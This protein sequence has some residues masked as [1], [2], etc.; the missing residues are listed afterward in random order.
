M[1]VLLLFS[2]CDDCLVCFDLV[3]V[4]YFWSA[5]LVRVC[6]LRGWCWELCCLLCL[7][8]CLCVWFVVCFALLHK[9]GFVFY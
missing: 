3:V 9:M 6:L 1:S 7:G 8:F 2:L 5:C 4:F